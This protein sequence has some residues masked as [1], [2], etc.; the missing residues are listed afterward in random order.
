MANGVLGKTQPPANTF[1]QLYIVP[2]TAAFATINISVC[3][4]G[5]ED[6]AVKL[7]IGTG[8]SPGVGDYIENGA[9]VPAAGGVLERT[10][11]VLSAGEKV[12]FYSDKATCA[13]RVYGLEQAAS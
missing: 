10:C 5:A 7:A 11:L 6:A 2:N 3:N 1:T 8:A 12:F 13:V 4:G 9:V